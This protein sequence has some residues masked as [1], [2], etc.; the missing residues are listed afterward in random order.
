MNLLVESH[1]LFLAAMWG[2]IYKA[3]M[4]PANQEATIA[5]SGYPK[6]LIQVQET[7][8]RPARVEQREPADKTVDAEVRRMMRMQPERKILYSLFLAWRWPALWTKVRRGLSRKAR[9]GDMAAYVRRRR[10]QL[11]TSQRLQ[12]ITRQAAVKA[13]R[14]WHPFRNRGGRHGGKVHCV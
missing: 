8:M 11:E 10:A 12:K 5:P 4:T 6:C 7:I 13:I 1:A 9:L 2:G 14:K 3:M